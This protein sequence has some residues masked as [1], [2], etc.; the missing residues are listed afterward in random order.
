MTMTWVL[1]PLHSVARGLALGVALVEALVVL[2]RPVPPHHWPN[3]V[4]FLIPGGIHLR[5]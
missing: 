1:Q 2:I 3:E 4:T 5:P